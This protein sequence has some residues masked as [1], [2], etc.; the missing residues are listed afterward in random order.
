MP[1]EKRGAEKCHL[2]ALE[3]GLGPAVEVGSLRN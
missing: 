3:K 2:L 1:L